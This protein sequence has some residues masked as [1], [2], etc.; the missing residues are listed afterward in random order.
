MQL[1]P[2]TTKQLA[3]IFGVCT[4]FFGPIYQILGVYRI[5]IAPFAA[6]QACNIDWLDRFPN[7]VD[8][9]A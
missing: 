4:Q 5:P 6:S 3:D 9:F 8:Q 1:K 7:V 2:A